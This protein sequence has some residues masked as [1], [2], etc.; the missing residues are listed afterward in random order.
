MSKGCFWIFIFFVQCNYRITL[1]VNCFLPKIKGHFGFFNFGFL[2]IISWDQGCFGLCII[3]KKIVGVCRARV[4]KW[5]VSVPF[6]R[7]VWCLPVTIGSLPRWHPK[8]RATSTWWGDACWS[9]WHGEAPTIIFLFP[10][11]F[12]LLHLRKCV[13]LAK[14]SLII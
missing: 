12:S 3:Q 8:H 2:G 4:N 5:E 11:L 7:R 13:G 10:S 1:A 9:S 6:R 14:W